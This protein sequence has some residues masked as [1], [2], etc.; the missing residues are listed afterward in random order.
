VVALAFTSV[1]SMLRVGSGIATGEAQ[2][3]TSRTS[4][5]TSSTRAR[6]RRRVEL[7]LVHRV[8]RRG[9]YRFDR[10]EPGAFIEGTAFDRHVLGRPKIERVKVQFLPDENAVLAAFLAGQV[11]ITAAP[12]LR[13]EHGRVL[14]RDWQGTVAFIP[15]QPQFFYIQMR[16]E[17]VKPPALGDV[18]VRKALAHAIDKQS[19]DETF[20]DGSGA[21]TYSMISPRAVPYYAEIERAVV[22]YPYD[23]QRTQQLLNEAGLTRGTDGMYVGP[24]GQRLVLDAWSNTALDFQRSLAAF[25]DGWSRLGIASQQSFLTAPELRDN[26]LRAKLPMHFTSAAVGNEAFAAGFTSSLA[27]SAANRWQGGNRGG[28]ANPDYDRLVSAYNATLERRER[29]QQIVQMERM[30]SGDLPI[31]MIW[32]NFQVVAYAA[33]VIGPDTRSV[34]DLVPWNVHEWEMR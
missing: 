17:Y 29:I 18:R 14:V 10:W 23:P 19:L 20:F 28:Y 34:R 30:V 3:W 33:S 24:D 13:Q 6:A 21:V 31:I 9:A 5:S 26:E 15:V 1:S 22:R 4:A 11:H 8:R 27:P 2:P 25:A 16:P 7:V 12:T 32:H